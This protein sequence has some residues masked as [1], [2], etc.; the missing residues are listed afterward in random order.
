MIGDTEAVGETMEGRVAQKEG[1]EEVWARC[2]HDKVISRKLHQAV[3][4][5]ITHKGVGC[6]LPGDVYTQTGS[7]VADILQEIHPDT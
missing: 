6:L 7:P 2:F 4:R 5:L 1:D 3:W